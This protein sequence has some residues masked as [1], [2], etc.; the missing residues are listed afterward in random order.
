MSR[1]LHVGSNHDESGERV[2]VT[3]SRALHVGSNPVRGVGSRGS[4]APSEGCGY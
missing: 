3:E 1:A 2:I 4:V